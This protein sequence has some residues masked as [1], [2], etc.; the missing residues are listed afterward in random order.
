MIGM[1]ASPPPERAAETEGVVEAERNF[2]AARKE[3]HHEN[4]SKARQ[5]QEQQDQ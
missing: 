1:E 5:A 2:L 3:W 4:A